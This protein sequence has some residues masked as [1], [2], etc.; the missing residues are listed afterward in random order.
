MLHLVQ[1][2]FK[3]FHQYS[4]IVSV[5]LFLTTSL[6]LYELLLQFLSSDLSFCHGN[7]SCSSF[8]QNAS[9]PTKCFHLPWLHSTIRDTIWYSVSSEGLVPP[10][11]RVFEIY[12]ALTSI[13]V[14]S[15]VLCDKYSVWT[16]LKQQITA[17]PSG[18]IYN[19]L[20]SFLAP[21]ISFPVSLWVSVCLW[22]PRQGQMLH[23]PHS[24]DMS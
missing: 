7:T 13:T 23:S 2:I 1:C 21:S 10:V 5:C 17:P 20:N 16:G 15:S 14:I 18:H 24:K 22:A 3:Q 19:S 4:N 9:K 6:L 8:T 12:T 11:V